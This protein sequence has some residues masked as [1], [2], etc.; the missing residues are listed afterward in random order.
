M[1]IYNLHILAIFETEER[2]QC[3]IVQLEVWLVG[4]NEA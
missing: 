4:E 2:G 3:G 1:Q